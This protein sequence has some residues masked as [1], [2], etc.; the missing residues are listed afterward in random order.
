MHDIGTPLRWITASL[1][2]LAVVLGSSPLDRMRHALS[3]D[4]NPSVHV[5]SGPF[6][7]VTYHSGAIVFFVLGF[8]STVQ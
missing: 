8:R 5:F 3:F 4:V 6:F 1:D 2:P 7:G